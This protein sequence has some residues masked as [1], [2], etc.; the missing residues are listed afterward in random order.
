MTKEQIYRK[1]M[2]DLGIWD[3][4]FD[5]ELTLLCQIE[6]EYTR[7]KKSWAATAP[8][9]GKPSFL[10]DH[11]PIIQKLRAE[12]LQHR[13][14]LGLTP[15]A[16]KKLTGAAVTDAPE[17]KELISH[18][19]DQIASRVMGYDALSDSPDGFGGIP[20]G[21]GEDVGADP[22]HDSFYG[23]PAAEEAVAI[24]DSMDRQDNPEGGGLMDE[25]LMKAVAEDMG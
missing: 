11:Y 18:K 19:L 17:A 5:P 2:Q 12:I 13:E 22:L 24:S 14:A 7:I 16:L 15:K 21:D 25:E 10:D 1:Q 8:P 20:G 3:P 9:G 4:V 6:R 23:I